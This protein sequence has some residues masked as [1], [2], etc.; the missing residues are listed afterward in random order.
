[1][2]TERATELLPWL[3]NGT[4]EG[5]ERDE[6]LNAL[7]TSEELRAELA[8]THQ[9]GEVFG[10]HVP[11]AD[12]VAHAFGEPTGL[13]RGRIEAH[14]ALCASCAE[15]LAMARES[16]ALAE[17]PESGGAAT[18][19]PAAPAAGE[20]RSGR[21]LAFLR[22][23]ASAGGGVAGWQ[24]AALAASVAAA[25]ALGG[26]IWTWQQSQ[27]RV[28]DLVASLRE[29]TQPA[30]GEMVDSLGLLPESEVLRGTRD[31]ELSAAARHGAYELSIY[32]ERITTADRY[33]LRLIDPAAPEG[34]R[35][36]IRTVPWEQTEGQLTFR[37]AVDRPEPGT[38]YTGEL[39][40]LVSGRGWV[41]IER[42]AVP[43][44]SRG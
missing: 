15:E 33:E 19:A 1:M 35:E 10:Q 8:E 28:N 39:V 12:L 22:P 40:R 9:A 21:L 41:L 44:G 7:R 24:A 32:D 27:G 18:T 43:V 6:V 25:V 36:L 23:S 5:P 26:W 37:V 16:H 29:G 11:A 31:R 20:R 3:L 38:T 42:Y 4:L 14:L 2:D 34:E 13:D 30:S 17:A